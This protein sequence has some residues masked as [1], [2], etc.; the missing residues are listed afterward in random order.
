MNYEVRIHD[1]MLLVHGFVVVQ[2]IFAEFKQISIKLFQKDR[3]II[4]QCL[5]TYN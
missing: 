2:L 4:L 1:I 3:K 5:A